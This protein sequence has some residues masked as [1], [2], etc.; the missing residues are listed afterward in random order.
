MS[1]F[2]VKHQ[3]HALRLIQRAVAR[4][5]IPHAYLFHGP[6]GVGKETLACGLA[7][8]LLCGSPVERAL[9]P[10]EAEI[11]GL[12]R[13][14]VGCGKCE[15]CRALAAGMHP[16]WH[17]IY[18]QLN[19]RHPEPQVR[20][21]KAM[22]L[23]VDVIRHFVID[24]VGLTPA[25]SRAKVFVIREADRFTPQAQNALLKTLEEPPG[26]TFL[27]LLVSSTDRLFSTTLSR[28][29]VV[30][31]NALPLNF[32]RDQLVE[33]RTDLP[34]EQIEWYAS[35][36]D[37]SIGLALGRIDDN[38]Y[39]LN[40][41]LI[42]GLARLSTAG[43]DGMVKSWMEEAQAQGDRCK[44]RDPDMTDTE[45][46]RSGLKSVIHLAA[47]WYADLLR[48]TSGNADSLVNVPWRSLI[49]QAAGAIDPERAASSIN[50]LA[51]AEQ[52][53]NLNANTQLCVEVLLSDLRGIGA[54]APT[55]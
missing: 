8:L 41:R 26:T 6:E 46:A 21:R 36:S 49:E 27:I 34:N 40:G 16:D 17:L 1:L 29:Q 15:D 55:Q 44:K 42:E 50:R 54:D 37:G 32:V 9:E 24:K 13:L 52:Q 12:D 11:V 51:L 4:Q 28:C 10:G 22:D 47:S 2:K 35:S 5:R 33:L 20:K 43:G 14:Q 25:R 23:G 48:L 31:F 30:P 39:E 53:L 7:Q 18:R 38:L 3:G 19:R 45:A